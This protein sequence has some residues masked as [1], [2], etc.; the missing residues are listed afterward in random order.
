DMLLLA[1]AFGGGLP[2]GAC[3][4]SRDIMGIL[5]NN[6]ILGHIS[7]FGGNPLCC[8]AGLAALQVVEQPEFLE[9]VKDNGRHLKDR[10]TGHH[11]IKEVRG[12]G[13]MLALELKV[14]DRLFDV[15][16]VCK[17]RGLLVD[18]F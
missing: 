10:L 7:T 17:Q 13:L 18:W 4:S 2:L 9:A 3:I 6:P 15:I 16:T 11:A 5:S 12:R 14:P 8:A 1:K